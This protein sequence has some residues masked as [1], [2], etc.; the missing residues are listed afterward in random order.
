MK[1]ING[2]VDSYY[3]NG[4]LEERAT[5]KDD[6]LEGLR[7]TWRINGEPWKRET[8]KNGVVE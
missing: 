5:Y 7:E 1:E 8:Y 4:Q 6:E 3:S 2:V